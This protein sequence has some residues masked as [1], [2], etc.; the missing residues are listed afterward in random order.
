[1]LIQNTDQ[2]LDSFCANLLQANY[3]TFKYILYTLL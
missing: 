3:C 1:M 2:G